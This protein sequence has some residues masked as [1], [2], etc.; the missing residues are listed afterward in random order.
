NY[1][2]ASDVDLLVVYSGEPEEDPFKLVKKTIEVSGLEP[3][4]YREE[5]YVGAKERLEKMEEEGVVLWKNPK[6]QK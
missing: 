3:H 4:I 1:T 6:N 2:A 5:E